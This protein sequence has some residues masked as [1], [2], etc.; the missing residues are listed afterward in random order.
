MPHL[1]KS[2]SGYQ[3][4]GIIRYAMDGRILH[5]NRHACETL[6]YAEEEFAALRIYDID[7]FL[8]EDRWVAHTGKL[9]A[10]GASLF[11]RHHRRKDGTIYPELV[12]T[13]F[14]PAGGA[15]SLLTYNHDISSDERLEQELRRTQY[16]LDHA[17]E[18]VFWTANDGSIRY[19]ND[20]A[21]RSLG[22]AREELLRMTIADIDP[23]VTPENYPTHWRRTLEQGHGFFETTHRA[24]DGR[25]Y[26]VEI[27]VTV[28]SFGEEEIHCTF[29]RDISDRKRAEA[30]LRESEERLRLALKA[31]NQGLYDADFRS[32]EVKV[33]PEYASMLGY[34]PATFR[35]TVESWVGML[36]PE[37]R[38]SVE[39]K[40]RAYLRGEFPAYSLEFRQRTRSGGYIWIS[41]TGKIVERDSDGRPVRMLGTHTDIT[42]RKE[43]EEALRESEYFLR[44]SQEVARLG[45]YKLDIS[46]GKWICS[47]MLED[48]FG[49]D[50]GYPRDVDGWVDL[51]VPEQREE[52]R[53]YLEKQV[54]GEHDRFEKEYRIV[55]RSDGRERWVSGFGELE[56]DEGGTPVRLIGTVQ[57]VTE[58]KRAELEREEIEKA[59][60]QA[61]RME[62]VGRL[63][64]GVAHEFNNMLA[65]IL[66]YAELM[67]GRI[68]EGDPMR[69]FVAEIERA[70]GRARDVTTQLLAFS[71][72]QVIA[73]KVVNLNDHLAVM[74]KTLGRLIGEEVRLVFHPGRGLWDT[75]VDPAQLD[76]VLVNLAVNARDAMPDGGRLTIETAN[77]RIDAR[78]SRDGA[79]VAP[80]D[81]VCLTVADEGVGMDRETLSHVFEPFYTTKEVGK[82][83]GLGL[84]TVYGIVDQN[85]GFIEVDSEPGTGT[86]F[87]VYL[88]RVREDGDAAAAQAPGKAETGSPGSILL[89]EDDEMVRRMVLRLLEDL[90]YK[91]ACAGS[92]LDALAL[93]RKPDF[94][95]DLLI[96]DVVMPGMNGRELWENV[97]ALRPGTGVLFMSGY[98]S[99]EIAGRGILDGEARFLNKPFTQRGL[100]QAVKEAMP[101][102]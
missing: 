95:V 5:A 31:S 62:T 97:K 59:L 88:P 54:F 51:I 28:V 55:R 33:S 86:S 84:P 17:R 82:G 85:G 78:H 67:R 76:Q 72:K 11:I 60:Q 47:P 80:G 46:S 3:P 89:V 32:G 2:F 7:P 81:Y 73:P 41:S 20:A 9:R 91:V 12:I 66:G 87:R 43:I 37:E 22:Y 13:Q 74:E 35:L 4:V 61:H 44:K 14:E 24:R 21:C 99:D 98:T 10:D 90:G 29:V 58:R 16:V 42:G 45:S 79:P 39:R 93:C 63:A 56:F 52:M 68:P 70:G 30:A 50:E 26:P 38:E 23:D 36:H 40:F 25:V 53:S 64:G 49:I 101:R 27:D 71:R 75:L 48:I 34:D 69:K 77:A 96:T 65:V 92:P 57:D 102:R 100:S 19:V 6:G 15:G 18:Q 1:L 83:S 8:T 94:P